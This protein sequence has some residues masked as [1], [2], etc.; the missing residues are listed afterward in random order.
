MIKIIFLSEPEYEKVEKLYDYLVFDVN[1]LDLSKKN[2]VAADFLNSSIIEKK[3]SLLFTEASKLNKSILYIFDT[4]D[5]HNVI[6]SINDSFP[7]M[8]FQFFKQENSKATAIKDI[9]KS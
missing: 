5:Y 3:L 4:E 1:Q 7:E 6:Q 2:D 9:H 8:K